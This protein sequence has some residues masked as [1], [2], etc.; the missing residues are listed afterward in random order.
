LEASSLMMRSIIFRKIKRIG[1]T[2]IALGFW[3]G[4]WQIAA[5]VVGQELLIPAPLLVLRR[6]AELG[7][8]VLF[9]QSAGGT[10]LRIFG[11]FLIGVVLG[12]VVGVL[13]A[14]WPLADL[15]LSP[16]VR[17]VRATPVASFI[18]LM[19]LWVKTGMLPAFI[20]AL[21]V[22]PILW[23]NVTRGIRETDPL[24]LEMGAL[25]GFGFW[26][27]KRLIYLPSVLPYFTS[28]C[29]TALG[30]AWKSGVA[31]EVLCLPKQAVGTQVYYSKLYLETPSLFAWTVVV[32]V[33]SFLV[34]G[35]LV[36]GMNRL[37]KRRGRTE[38]GGAG[39][40]A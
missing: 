2:L 11:G 7:G 35:V 31:A 13:T 33:L 24:L 4:L 1:R 27:E 40:E 26:K 3:L 25:Y 20:S 39:A 30:L 8:T 22:L 9:W 34:E 15:L 28:G 36:F 16:A 19:L 23:G 21:M 6:L 14:S 37:E 32:I 17:V 18:V 38:G 5:M 10:L 29:K 12:T